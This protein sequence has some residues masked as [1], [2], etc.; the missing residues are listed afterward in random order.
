M[1]GP[2]FTPTDADMVPTGGGIDSYSQLDF[3]ASKELQ[4]KAHASLFSI[5]DSTFQFALANYCFHFFI[6]SLNPI[7]KTID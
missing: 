2:T 3:D 5:E 6:L 7:K 4:K 1:A